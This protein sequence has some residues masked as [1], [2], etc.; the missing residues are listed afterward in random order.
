[1]DYLERLPP[2]EKPHHMARGRAKIV[3]LA[4]PLLVNGRSLQNVIAIVPTGSLRDFVCRDSAGFRFVTHQEEQPLPAW[5]AQLADAEWLIGLEEI[6]S[7][8][9]HINASRNHTIIPL[10]PI[11][12]IL[13]QQAALADTCRALAVTCWH[14]WAA[15]GNKPCRTVAY[16]LA[17]ES[18]LLQEDADDLVAVFPHEDFAHFVKTGDALRVY[19]SPK[20]HDAHV[21]GIVSQQE[22]WGNLVK[23]RVPSAPYRSPP[24]AFPVLIPILTAASSE[25]AIDLGVLLWRAGHKSELARTLW[26]LSYD[27]LHLPDP[28]WK[29]IE[30]KPEDITGMALQAAQIYSLLDPWRWR[31]GRYQQFL[32]GCY[33]HVLDCLLNQETLANGDLIALFYRM[34]RHWYGCFLADDMVKALDNTVNTGRQYLSQT[35]SH[36]VTP[37]TD[38]TKTIVDIGELCMY[39]VGLRQMADVADTQMPKRALEVDVY[40][41]SALNREVNIL[42]PSAPFMQRLRAYSV[43]HARWIAI[44]ESLGTERPSFDVLDR[45][46]LRKSFDLLRQTAY[47][48]AHEEVILRWA[49][50]EDMERIDRLM[51]AV[52]TGPIIKVY[53]RN[54][55]VSL[56][57]E[58]RLRVDIENLGGATAVQLH[59]ELRRSRQFD[60]VANSPALD[61][62]TFLPGQQQRLVWEIRP[63][64]TAV[65]LQVVCQYVDHRG[66]LQTYEED[67]RVNVTTPQTGQLKPVGNLYQAGPPVSGWGRFFGRRE[68]LDQIL[69]R[70]IGGITQ[71]ILLRGPR[72]MGK[73]SI[74]RQLEW[75]LHNNN[76]QL[77][78]LGLTPEQEIQLN[79]CV[80]VFHTLQSISNPND[81]SEF[82]RTIYEDICDVLGLK[83]DEAKLLPQFERSPTRAFMRQMAFVFQQRPFIR[84]LVI[85]DEWDELYRS[86]Y[87]K[88]AL[89]L[90]SLMEGEVRINWLVS[91]TWT[92]SEEAGRYGSPFYN[93]AYTIELREMDWQQAVE[94]VTAPG[95]KMGVTWRGEAVVA[96]LDQT[97]RRPYLIQLVCSKLTDYLR[98]SRV[99]IVNTADITVVT[100]QIIQEAQA[101]AQYFGFLWRNEQSDSKD[102]VNWMG[103]LILWVMDAHHPQPMTRIRIR[104]AIEAEFQRRSL[105]QLN[106]RFFNEQFNDQ[107]TQLQWIFDALSVQGDRYVFSVPLVQRWLRRVIS[108]QKEPVQQAHAGLLQAQQQW[109]GMNED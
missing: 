74:L 76:Q 57:I 102:G 36:T 91:S 46:R 52:E 105:L 60:F 94:L 31:Q 106:P 75:L 26:L 59:V 79:A 107:I 9:P 19:R 88:L 6:G 93:Q 84:P 73:T 50:Q 23:G 24:I 69:T 48:P 10:R 65:S 37:V 16:A 29:V 42:M 63:R 20:I 68:E 54:P 72:R 89:N 62:A 38:M 56:G 70:L 58:E 18:W 95:E 17:T 51:Q 80:P 71:P 11:M 32:T 43:Y 35:A 7:L 61:I 55:W 30:A 90:R 25:D 100:Q 28:A 2:A 67:I 108:Q 21:H 77:R 13:K 49:I 99:N 85:I 98:R 96:V 41:R 92:L 82:F 5:P 39:G 81:T 3:R 104:E 103:K 34:L 47:A 97:G 45:D 14:E 66:Q 1:L 27:L 78:T 64:E 22:Y 33:Q 4:L 44:Q 86:A 83:Y 109:Q 8:I 40:L 101:T 15:Q 53:L 87:T 12:R